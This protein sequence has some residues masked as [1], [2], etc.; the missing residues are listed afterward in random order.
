VRG[1]AAV[2]RNAQQEPRSST[3][4]PV[5]SRASRPFYRSVRFWVTVAAVV[6]GI[7]LLYHQV[8]LDQVRDTAEKLNGGV[9]FALLTLLPLVGFPV[10]V[11]HV[12]AGVRFGVP[13]G[14][15]LV[16]L[17]ILLQLLACYGL[18]HWKRRFFAKRFKSL[19][20]KVPKGAHASVTV[21]TM[22][23]PGAPFFAQ[24]YTL[25]LIGVPL[26][27]YLPICLPMH[28]ARS[29]IAVILGGESQ[30]LTPARLLLLLLYV[31]AVL[32]ASWWAWRRI[33]STLGD[34]PVVASGR[35]QPA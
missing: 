21:F 22:L 24:N 26:R 10:S 8:D 14:L 31:A 34:R 11:L 30:H 6:A 23:I 29:S 19:R 20:D 27:L 16:W 25:A 2:R 9:A 1:I 35:K 28:A 17:S 4:P 33:R 12:A 7:A 3:A 18:V 15:A 32:G 5:P 13:L